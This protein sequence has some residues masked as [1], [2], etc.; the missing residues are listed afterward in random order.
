MDNFA[1]AAACRAITA[2]SVAELHCADR[3]QRV[4]EE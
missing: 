1:Q 2:E 3:Y 4:D